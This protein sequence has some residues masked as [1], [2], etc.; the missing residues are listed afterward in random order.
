MPANPPQH[1]G[2][3][4]HAHY[5]ASGSSRTHYPDAPGLNVD[6]GRDYGQAEI[7]LIIEAIEDKDNLRVRVQDNISSTERPKITRERIHQGKI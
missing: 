3:S 5:L 7:S 6:T 2:G 1:G 4:R